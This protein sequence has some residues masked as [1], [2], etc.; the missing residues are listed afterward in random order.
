VFFRAETFHGALTML[1]GMMNLPTALGGR[2]GRF[3]PLLESVGF[4]FSGGYVA[5]EPA[6]PRKSRRTVSC[7]FENIL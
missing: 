2:F 4:Q 3:Q 6:T 5:S 7:N 1:R